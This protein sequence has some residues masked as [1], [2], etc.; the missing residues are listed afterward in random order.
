VRLTLYRV[1]TEPVLNAPLFVELARA[2]ATA[3]LSVSR[4][5]SPVAMPTRFGS[6]EVSDLDLGAGDNPSIPCLG[7]RSAGLNG[8]FRISGFACGAKA[9]PMSTPALTCLI[10]RLDLN[11]AGDDQA[12]ANFFA[13]SELR[14]PGLRRHGAGS[15]ADRN[16][17]DR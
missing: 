14:R 17:V 8:G 7:F 10:D 4:S 5:L 6:F 1:G 15:D 16:H 11:S 12:L 2:A 9:Q 3:G 13:A